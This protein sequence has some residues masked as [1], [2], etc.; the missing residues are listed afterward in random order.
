MIKF[1]EIIYFIIFFNRCWRW[2]QENGRFRGID[3]D[4][5]KW[6]IY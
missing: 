5:R 3:M 1:V 2:W 4:S 6:F